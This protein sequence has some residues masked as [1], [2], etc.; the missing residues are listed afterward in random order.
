MYKTQ[1]CEVCNREY[2]PTRNHQK[3]CSRECWNKTPR[4]NKGKTGL[5]Q[6]W[7][8]QDLYSI[9]EFC[10]KEYKITK[11]R[12]EETR[13]C[14]R[15]CQNRWLAKNIDRSGKNNCG[16][17]GGIQ[18]Y[19][20]KAR[21]LLPDQCNRC[22]TIKKLL[23]HHKDEN[24]YNNPDDGSNW[25]ILCKK[26]HQILHECRKNLPTNPRK[27]TIYKK[28]CPY[29]KS[30]F[31]TSDKLKKFCN[32]KCFGLS[33]I[34]NNPIDKTCLYCENIFSTTRHDQKFCSSNCSNRYKVL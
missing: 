31:E 18:L 23:V 28:I 8:K 32:R 5:Q 9:C 26:C 15:T 19:R 1:I 25:E 4:W 11:C 12:I 17:K 13:F 20:E 30:T 33:K 10:N 2:V 16:Y 3:Y 21:K 7:N 6:A 27:K 29:C 22:G 34:I 24:R 14:S